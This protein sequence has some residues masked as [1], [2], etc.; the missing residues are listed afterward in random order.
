MSNVRHPWVKAA[1]PPCKSIRELAERLRARVPG[2]E[3]SIPVLVNYIGQQ[4]VEWFARRD[5]YLDALRDITGL[6]R[7]E[8]LREEGDRLS[9]GSL[10]AHELDALDEDPAPILAESPLDWLKAGVTVATVPLGHGRSTWAY[11]ARRRERAD[12]IDV[13]NI[14]ELVAG[15]YDRPALVLVDRA[16]LAEDGAILGRLARKGAQLMV[17]A[18]EVVPPERTLADVHV[19]DWR[20]LPAWRETL[21]DYLGRRLRIDA[22]R[23]KRVTKDALAL[24]T[25][26]PSSF[27]AP[28][29]IVELL[30]V[31]ASTG[32]TRRVAI[33]LQGDEGSRSALDELPRMRGIDGRRARELVSALRCAIERRVVDV[34]KSLEGGLTRE[35]WTELGLEDLNALVSVGLLRER[36]GML[37]VFPDFVARNEARRHIEAMV[38]RGAGWGRLAVE[39]RRRHDIDR[40]LDRIDPAVLAK[41]I[42]A[43]LASTPGTL[44]D[45]GR[46]E[47]LFAAVGRRFITNPRH[48]IPRSA[49]TQL[50]TRATSLWASHYASGGVIGP[51]TRPAFRGTEEQ[52]AEFVAECWAW[53]FNVKPP[54]P[55]DE[56]LEAHFP[57]WRKEPWT[58]LP[59]WWSQVDVERDGTVGKDSDVNLA[60]HAF[61]E[62]LAKHLAQN[63]FDAKLPPLLLAPLIESMPVDSEAARWLVDYRWPAQR[64]HRVAAEK[65]WRIVLN[66]HGVTQGLKVL[67]EIEAPTIPAEAAKAI[68][69]ALPMGNIEATE[70][71]KL[72]ANLR[73]AVLARWAQDDGRLM[74]VCRAL[75]KIAAEKTLTA[76]ETELILD[77]AARRPGYFGEAATRAL[78]KARPGTALEMLRSAAAAADE[79]KAVE[80][81]AVTAPAVHLPAVLSVLQTYA[82]TPTLQHWLRRAIVDTPSAS[83]V[84]WL[85]LEQSAGR[86]PP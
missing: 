40:Y 72:P 28:A 4:R 82:L 65:V 43:S 25:E 5:Q 15:R 75:E 59:D 12:V 66:R 81:F 46:S 1:K 73:G 37:H 7:S 78:W 63:V 39:P 23:R 16:N 64:A 2:A 29:E 30:V 71:E 55:H 18:R 11:V 8:L 69:D 33:L 36:A 6:S 80:R 3:P 53:S 22:P 35:Q 61:A 38:A 86:S 14:G 31:L 62:R 74:Q 47:S 51:I 24:V 27:E 57:G 52:R 70:P 48:L 10:P 49:L 60:L 56:Q 32:R 58:T 79:V 67:D 9:F 84:A 17:L 19:A 21:V 85:L 54:I 50:F 42:E 34:G 68:V 13:G 83:D 77:I 41:T 26:N 44:D 45:A 76:T 20:F